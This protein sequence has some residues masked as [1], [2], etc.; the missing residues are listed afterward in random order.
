M[1]AANVHTDDQV[2][3]AIAELHRSYGYVADPHTAI[4]YLGTKAPVHPGT[5]HLSTSA[6]RST[7]ALQ[8]PSTPAPQHLST[9][10]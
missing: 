1:I 5:Q 8:H 6:P 2:K 9:Y 10:S 3:A 7:S 4:A